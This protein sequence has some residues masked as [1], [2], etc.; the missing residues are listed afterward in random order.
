[1]GIMHSVFDSCVQ[2]TIFPPFLKAGDVAPVSK[3]DS[4]TNNSFWPISILPIILNIYELSVS[5]CKQRTGSNLE[6]F[7]H[8]VLPGSI[9]GFFLFNI[10]MCHIFLIAEKQYIA[11]FADVNPIWQQRQCKTKSRETIK[12]S[13]SILS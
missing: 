1:M 10:H 11:S 9:S 13:F 4:R 5:N 6:E 12:K 2:N 8:G 7:L 3:E